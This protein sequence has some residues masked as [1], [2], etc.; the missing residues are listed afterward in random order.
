MS[1][2]HRYQ[3]AKV[4]TLL[5][6]AMN[7]FLGLIKL[8]GGMWFSSHALVA[9][10]IHSFA[11][12]ITDLMVVFAS[13]YGSQDPDDQHPYGHQRIETAATFLLSVV[14]IITGAGIA[15]DSVHDL[16]EHPQIVPKLMTIPLIVFSIVA[17]EWFFHYTQR[18]GKKIRSE[19]LIANAWHHRADAGASLI[20]FL[21]I[22]GSM[23]GY[24]ALDPLAAIIIG[25][26]IIKMGV[27]YG[28]N[29]VQE[30]IDTSISADLL[31]DIE[32]QI[33]TTPGVVK[34]HQLRNRKMGPDLYLDVH[35]QVSPTIS[36]S[37]GHYIAQNVHTGLMAHDPNI[38]DVT[39]HVDPEDDETFAPSGHLLHRQQL[40][41]LL[42]LPWQ[43]DY[44]AI[45]SWQLHYL[46]GSIRID[47]IISPAF[48]QWVDLDQRIAHDV[49]EYAQI[50]SI[51][52]LIQHTSLTP[53]SVPLG[54][55]DP[56]EEG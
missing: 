37:E 7:A 18:I 52:V 25:G 22:L 42:L 8:V 36:V 34:M 19:L 31:A 45:K 21:G 49:Q 56:Y 51:H 55:E 23:A 4:V 50:S 27:N 2:D 47:L 3:S 13:K 44:P 14:L 46:T 20:V 29:S 12:L 1:T 35:I 11:D 54:I 26:L 15:W 28:W 5:G 38:K 6:G 32:H 40:E 48:S 9:D 30:L 39:V 41:S 24:H 17:N 16:L 43:Q 53:H 10:G 33:R